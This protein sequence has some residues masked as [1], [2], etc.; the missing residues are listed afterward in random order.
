[1]N[2]QQLNEVLA[3]LGGQRRLFWYFPERF[4]FLLLAQAS[5]RAHTLRALKQRPEGRLLERAAVRALL[6]HCGDGALTPD[7]FR[8]HWDHRAVPFVLNLGYW[9]GRGYR[10]WRQTSRGGYNLVLRLDFASDHMQELK[11]RFGDY[12][13]LYNCDSHPVAQQQNRLRETLAWARLDLDF[14]SDE[15]LIEEIQSDWV[16]DAKWASTHGWQTSNGKISS[17]EAR[18]YLEEVLQP[19]VGIWAEAMLMATLWFIHEELGISRVFYHEYATGCALKQLRYD[20][21][22]RS[23]YSALPRRFCMTLVDH[24]PK[25][26]QRDKRSQRVLKRVQPHRFYHR[27]LNASG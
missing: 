4:A 18:S 11:R 27:R 26:L 22:P 24:A 13:W 10:P 15:V 12:G 17:A 1:M 16:R 19:I 6:K 14:D 25:F 8:S 5:E 21:P 7:I 9:G 23:L 20:K 3:C 2:K